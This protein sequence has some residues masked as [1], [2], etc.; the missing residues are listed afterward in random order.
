MPNSSALNQIDRCVY[1]LKGK[2]D[3]FSQS[4]HC[5]VFHSDPLYSR[6]VLDKSSRMDLLRSCGL[7]FGLLLIA[8]LPTAGAD[9]FTI[10]SPAFQ[11]GSFI[12]SQYSYHRTNRAPEL[13]FAHVPPGAK[14]LVLIVDD[15]DFSSGLWTHWLLWNIPV[16]TYALYADK[17]PPHVIQG[18][19]SFGHVGYD[20]P[21]PPNGTHRYFFRVYALDNVLSLPAGSERNALDVAMTGHAI[22]HA[23]MFGKYSQ[24]L[25]VSK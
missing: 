19:N 10:S 22:D 14:S 9:S 1:T 24:H 5:L 7:C 2:I 4:S 25:T 12:P 8:I 23:E 3:N 18:K 15:P 13:R 21:W 11:N 17:L 6:R 16:R 20:G